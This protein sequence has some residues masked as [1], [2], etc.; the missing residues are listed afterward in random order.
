MGSGVRPLTHCSGSGSIHHDQSMTEVVVRHSGDKRVAL[1]RDCS[2]NM[3]V[4]RFNDD[5]E[6][7]NVESESRGW[8]SCD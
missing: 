8:N 7:Q 1:Y 6:E 3:E 4:S 5:K 2:C